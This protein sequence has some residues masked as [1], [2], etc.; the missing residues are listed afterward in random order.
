VILRS[1]LRNTNVF[2]DRQKW[3]AFLCWHGQMLPLIV[4]SFIFF[5]FYVTPGRF[6]IYLFYMLVN[7]GMGGTLWAHRYT[8]HHSYIFRDNLWGKFWMLVAQNLVIKVV[9][10]ELYAIS[11]HIHHAMPEKPG[12]PYNS[13]GGLLY[14]F[15]ADANHQPISLDLKEE[16]YAV[17]SQLLA[18]VPMYRNT[19]EE[20]KYW[21]SVS[22]PADIVLR[23]FL[24]W[25]M[26]YAI[27]CMVPGGGHWLAVTQFAAAGLW[28]VGIRTFNFDSHGQGK[29]MHEDGVDFHRRDL[30]TNQFIPGTV[31]GEWHNNHHLFPRSANCGFLWWQFD[32]TFQII[33][34]MY[35][36]GG[37]KSYRDD[38]QRF[39]EKMAAME[40]EKPSMGNREE[41]KQDPPAAFDGTFAT[42]LFGIFLF[43]TGCANI[44]LALIY[45]GVLLNW[46]SLVE[47]IWQ[48]GFAGRA[49]C[50]LLGSLLMLSITLLDMAK[51]GEGGL[52]M[53]EW[54]R[55]QKH[56]PVLKVA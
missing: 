8:T 17:T 13:E 21:G 44:L 36:L 11:H 14:C 6:L 51:R 43:A 16:E 48:G 37:V 23:Q 5:C 41:E 9:P 3:L 55:S 54:R 56:A 22:N 40:A 45:Q 1:W 46:D 24:N 52:F 7:M 20:Y 53:E 31:S 26:H 12:D 30:S 28:A 19:Y 18:H 15:L 27:C 35:L 10:D 49:A 29:V 42:L 25:V 32:G 4:V 39:L 34:L 2:A 50:E 38:R 47:L 33:K